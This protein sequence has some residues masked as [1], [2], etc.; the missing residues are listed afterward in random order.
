MS[1]SISLP[2]QQGA[3]GKSK[4]EPKLP[5]AGRTTWRTQ[6]R[7]GDSNLHCL[8]FPVAWGRRETGGGCAGLGV[9]E[10]P[11]GTPPAIPGRRKM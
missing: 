7:Q 3:Q 11:D 2:E 1:C 9:V 8:H 4:T 5:P 10:I 6:L